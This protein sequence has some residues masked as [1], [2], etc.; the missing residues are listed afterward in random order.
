[1]PQDAGD[2][3]AIRV[4]RAELTRLETWIS[5][6]GDFPP[7]YREAVDRA[8]ELRQQLGLPAVE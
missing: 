3:E 4:M 5:S 7:A 6:A 1:M 8:V 2:R